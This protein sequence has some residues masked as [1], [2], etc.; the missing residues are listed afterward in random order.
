MT[1]EECHDGGGGGGGGGGG[2]VGQQVHKLNME[3]HSTQ[4][5]QT[6]YKTT[7]A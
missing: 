4:E 1:V 6:M 7:L 2:E 3:H 5:Q